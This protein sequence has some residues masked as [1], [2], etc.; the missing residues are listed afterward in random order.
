VSA[1]KPLS[2]DE[3][4]QLHE[5]YS[6]LP[7]GRLED[8]LREPG[9]K[10]EARNLITEELSRRGIKLESTMKY[11]LA[12]QFSFLGVLENRTVKVRSVSV[13]VHI[14]FKYDSCW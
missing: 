5:T 13:K 11:R 6:R 8:L 2:P 1:E 3:T 4:A 14:V 9:L 10:P 7:E 12:C